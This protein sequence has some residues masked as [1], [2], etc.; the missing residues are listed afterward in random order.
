M[1]SAVSLFLC[2]QSS[3]Y[4]FLSSFSDSTDTCATPEQCMYPSCITLKVFLKGLQI[5]IQMLCKTHLN[6]LIPKCGLNTD[7]S[8]LLPTPRSCLLWNASVTGG[9][10]SNDR[11]VL[12]ACANV[13]LFISDW[14]SPPLLQAHTPPSQCDS[15][16]YPIWADFTVPFIY[17]DQ[18]QPVSNCILGYVLSLPALS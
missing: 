6:M 10:N 15:W 1:I 14:V 17:V 11:P 2:R 16:P 12:C 18:H 7:S 5:T 4:S 8:S 9:S 13:E 3:S